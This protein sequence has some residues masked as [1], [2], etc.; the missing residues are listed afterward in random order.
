MSTFDAGAARLT[1]FSFKEGLLSRVAHD[2]EI[3]VGAF[4]GS[5]EGGVVRA[6][7]DA[8]SLRVLH[9]LK[10]GAP[11]PGALSAADKREIEG[12]IR[13]KVLASGAHPRITFTARLADR[14]GDALPGELTLR[15]QRRPVTLTLTEAGGRIEARAR[16][17]QRDFGITPFKAL[18][19]A[20][21]VQDGV[22]VVADL[23]RELLS[24]G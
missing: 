18:M 13:E 3:Q 11:D 8:A 20:L 15:G 17:S 19:G 6:E 23:P 7:V 22:E 10:A 2:L 21:K 14:R 1:V 12:N 9:A 4:T 5:V 24:E 16:L